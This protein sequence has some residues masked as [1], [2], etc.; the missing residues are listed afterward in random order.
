[1]KNATL[2]KI[3]ALAN[4]FAIDRLQPTLLWSS[5]L[6][7]LSISTAQ[8]DFDVAGSV[9][10]PSTSIPVQNNSNLWTGNQDRSCKRLLDRGSK[11]V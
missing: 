2:H 11:C 4:S 9:L 8:M 10:C 3:D 1:M 6:H 7:M 5:A